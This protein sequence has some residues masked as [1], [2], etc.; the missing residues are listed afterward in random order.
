MEWWNVV[1]YQ[2]ILIGV[3]FGYY[4]WQLFFI[5]VQDL[6]YEDKVVQVGDLY[7][8]FFFVSV[9]QQSGYFFLYNYWYVIQ[10]DG[11]D[12]VVVQDCFGYYF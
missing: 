3:D 7:Y 8:Y 9:L 6:V 11:F 1:W 2:W 10:V 5:F 4:F 12:V